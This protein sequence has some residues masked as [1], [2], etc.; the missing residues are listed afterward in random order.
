[1][2]ADHRPG[3]LE[4]IVV[5]NG[6]TDDTAQRARAFGEPVTVVD[7]SVPGK[8]NA[9]NV[10]DRRAS[11][12]PRMY[13][14]ADIVVSI[15]ALRAIAHLLRDDSPIV[16]GAPRAVIDYEDHPR[17]AKSFIKVWTSLPYFTENLIGAGFYAFS[18]QGRERFDEFPDIIADDGFAR[19]QARPEERGTTDGE[20]T[21]TIT[22][23]SSLR[24][25]AK[26]M[27]R[28]HA[29][30][31]QLRERF[32]ELMRNENTSP[33]RSL[34]IVASN[35]RLW[36]HAPVYFGVIAYAKLRA[37]HKLRAQQTHVWERDETSRRA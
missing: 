14:D 25:I 34:E 29:G 6:C 9:L 33:S 11:G 22:P 21:F 3:E 8:A 13:V 18:R 37:R 35:P 36:I 20:H 28:V 15:E 5:P 31:Y 30:A 10:G 2:L 12:W 27:S 7:T 4:I 32:P 26:V 1:M 17:L 23:P 24:A 16:V 19:L